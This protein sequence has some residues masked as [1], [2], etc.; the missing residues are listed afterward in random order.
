MF[1]RYFWH[2]IELFVVKKWGKWTKLS[3]GN[4]EPS[5]GVKDL[6]QTSLISQKDFRSSSLP[7]TG[8]RAHPGER[9]FQNFL[10]VGF[11][12]HI[13]MLV[14]YMLLR[15]PNFWLLDVTTKEKNWLRKTDASLIYKIWLSCFMHLSPGQQT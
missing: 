4:L 2:L 10:Q 9:Q 14:F 5:L 11:G 3:Q 1:P 7:R 8:F 15:A 12:A 13:W 6:C